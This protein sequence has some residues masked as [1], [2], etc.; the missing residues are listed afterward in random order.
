VRNLTHVAL[1]ECR[2]V[3]GPFRSGWGRKTGEPEHIWVELKIA[4]N[5]S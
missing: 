2:F 1:R 3:L 5:K 4:E